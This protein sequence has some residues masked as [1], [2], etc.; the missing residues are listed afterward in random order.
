[1]QR[2]VTSRYLYAALRLALGGVFIY[3]GATKLFDPTAF[4]ANIDQYGLVTWRMANL[5]ART[6]PV[7]EVITG[8]GLVLDVR[9]ALGLIVAQLLVFMAVLGYAI[10]LGLDVD[11][12]CFGPSDPAAG[13][14]GGM[15]QT[16]GRDML[17][18]G[19]CLFLYAQRRFG[20][21]SPRS[22]LRPFHPR[23][24]EAP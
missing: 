22:P 12:G 13:G 2:I 1:M 23:N 5:L 15:W 17:M 14:S 8:L 10:H 6:L 18:L 9:G 4:A 16:L 11:C 19:A 20:G 3:A 7:I 24:E 21:F